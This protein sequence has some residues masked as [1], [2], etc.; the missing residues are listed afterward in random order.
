MT[1]G[2]LAFASFVFSRLD[3]GRYERLLDETNGRLVLSKLEH[4][5]A[6][7]RWLSAWGIRAIPKKCHYAPSET[8]DQL[9][10][11][12]ENAK[13]LHRIDRNRELKELSDDDLV[14]VS[15]AYDGLVK[16]VKFVGPT[17]A[18]KILFATRPKALM[19][20]DEPIQ[21]ELG[22]DGSGESYVRFLKKVRSIVLR[23]GTMCDKCSFD[24]SELPRKLGRPRSTIPKLIDEYFWV[25]ITN[26]CKPTKDDFLRWAEWSSYDI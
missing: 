26:K 1:L 23:L 9:K 3:S 2:E 16:K 14:L 24:L 20:W 10:S 15:D 25:T 21:K 22:Y 18:A 6:T 17:A 5:L 12:Y 11:W 8:S 19:P 13:L 7:L 4:R